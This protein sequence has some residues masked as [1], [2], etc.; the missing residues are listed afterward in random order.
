[1]K[2][3]FYLCLIGIF[4]CVITQT[5]FA[6]KPVLANTK[7]TFSK[8]SWQIGLKDGYG[9]SPILGNRNT[10]QLTAGY[11]VANR[12]L[13]GLAGSYTRELSEYVINR[14]LVSLGPLVRYQFISGRISPYAELSYQLGRRGTN[15]EQLVSFTP[16]LSIGLLAGLRLDLSYNFQYSHLDL[17][18]NLFGEAS[19][20]PQ[21]GISY[22]IKS[23]Q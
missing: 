9:S 22:L 10:A 2:R 23:R 19:R 7:T 5:V 11:Y 1:M 16:G 6:Q 15:T 14:N 4:S 8:G 18:Y 13:I 3:F 20:Q 21:I 12:L 17:G